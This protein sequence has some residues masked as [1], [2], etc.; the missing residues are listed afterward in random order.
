VPLQAPAAPR[1]ASPS[2]ALG[3]VLP[4]PRPRSGPIAGLAAL[5][6][7]TLAI[8]EVELRKLRRDPTELATRAIQPALWLLIFGQVFTRVRAIPTGDIPYI[9]FMTPGI[10]AQSVLFTAIF[11]GLSV[12]WE[13]D[14]G[15]LH[16][17]LVSPTPRA[18]LVLGKALAAGVRGV[19]QAA[20]IYG[21][22]L[23]LGVHLDPDPLAVG[24]VLV[25]VLLGAAAFAT[26]SM[27]VACLVRS[28]ERF[29]GIGQVM[30]MPLFFASN[31][32]YPVAIMPGWLQALSRLNPLSYEVD[33][34]RS[35]MI[36]GAASAYGVGLDLL[37]L[38][39]LT[40]VLVVVASRLYP[41]VVL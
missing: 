25:A 9:D 15:I 4:A 18:A 6:R 5:V 38:A 35:R 3:A 34:L 2:P 1:A 21:L 28:R 30:T 27:I 32:I 26:F 17:Y 37:V 39:G 14:L 16:K 29:M 22:A 12:I 20:V 23:V 8:T 10:L 40:A 24:G 41:R 11:Y 13:R 36:V 19:L 31:A 33:A 7:K